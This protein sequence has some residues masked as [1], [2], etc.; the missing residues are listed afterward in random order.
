[1]AS[2]GVDMSVGT[3]RDPRPSAAV[4][5]AAPATPG[6]ATGVGRKEPLLAADLHDQDA[7]GN[8]WVVLDRSAFDPARVYP[9]AMLVAGTEDF[10]A[11]VT[12]LRT[13]LRLASDGRHA[14]H[15]TFRPGLV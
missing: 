8:N 1:M 3:G 11:P 4:G 7:D 15:V 2:L 6:L 14:V 13:E 10:H 9:G 5:M 12:V